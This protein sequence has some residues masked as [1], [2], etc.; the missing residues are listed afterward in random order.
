[1]FEATMD[2]RRQK[3]HRRRY[4]VLAN[5]IEFFSSAACLP[6]IIMW[7][8]DLLATFH[9]DSNNSNKTKDLSEK[10]D[11]LLCI[12]LLIALIYEYNFKLSSLSKIGKFEF[13]AIWLAFTTLCLCMCS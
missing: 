4:S 7:S 3:S 8:I 1:M 9:Q 10:K 2:A 12:F 13:C 6:L 11:K 5:V